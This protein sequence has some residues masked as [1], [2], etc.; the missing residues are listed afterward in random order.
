MNDE[1]KMSDEP[2]GEAILDLLLR[3]L[4][5]KNS[6]ALELMITPHPRLFEIILSPY[7]F[8]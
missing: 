2:A 5:T 8:P 3:H 7:Y 4:T 1:T 6:A